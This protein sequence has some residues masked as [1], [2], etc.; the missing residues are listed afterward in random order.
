MQYFVR[1]AIDFNIFHQSH[2]RIR[3][4]R[5]SCRIRRNFRI[6]R[7]FDIR[8]NFGIR[9]NCRNRRSYLMVIQIEMATMCLI[10]SR[11]LC[12]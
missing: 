10:L 2:R 6:R 3:H 5:R 1:W 9:H 8:R 7:S 11:G 12:V 4:S